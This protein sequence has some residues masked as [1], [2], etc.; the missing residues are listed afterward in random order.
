MKFPRFEYVS[1]STIEEAAQLLVD[2]DDARPIAGGQSLLPLMA[3]RLAQ[4]T[5]LVDLAAIPGLGDISSENGSVRIGAM[6]TQRSAELSPVVRERL[7]LLSEALSHVGHPV[8]RNAGTIGG[9]IAHAD[10]AAEI[11]LAM[12]ALDAVV[13]VDGP[14][15][16]RSIA[17]ADFFVGAFTTALN[18]GELVTSVTI[19]VSSERWAFNE[20]ARRSGDFA[21][22][23]AAVGMSRDGDRC[24]AARIALGGVDS[25]P[26][27]AVE[28]E[29]ILAGKV[30]DET[31]A[32]E[33]ARAATAN[34]SPP[35]DIHGSAA[36]RRK[37]AAVLVQRAILRAGSE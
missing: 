7:P 2:D 20:L 25:R 34:I 19:P 14:K 9:S 17:A 36:Y 33:A 26:V 6:A 32:A 1:P 18:P 35:S 5:T 27:R 16:S 24:T 29:A 31:V 23:M 37:V 13:D 21:L 8:I 4:P 3:F 22:A 15:G 28:A 12:V 30:I 11:P 10:P